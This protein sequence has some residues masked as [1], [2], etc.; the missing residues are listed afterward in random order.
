MTGA[1]WTVYVLTALGSGVLAATITSYGPQAQARRSARAAARTALQIAQPLVQKSSVLKE[2]AEPPDQVYA[3][4][5]AVETAAMLAAVPDSV[6]RLYAL[7]Q[8]LAY[9]CFLQA[10]KAGQRYHGPAP[11]SLPWESERGLARMSYLTAV[12]LNQTL[13]HPWLTRFRR[14]RRVT[15]YRRALRAAAP[16]H[17][18][19]TEARNTLRR[20]EW[21]NPKGGK[22]LKRR[23]TERTESAPA[24]PSP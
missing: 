20:A 22:R 24:S 8:R 15:I 18:E 19:A 14:P 7:A 11:V 5:D 2:G 9:Q 1:S 13:W 17:I 4:I 12:L 6:V 10:A 3:A 21:R 16:V 23:S